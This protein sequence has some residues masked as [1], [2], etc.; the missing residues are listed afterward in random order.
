MQFLAIFLGRKVPTNHTSGK[1]SCE[2]LLDART[3][4]KTIAET[5]GITERTACNL[6]KAKNGGNDGARPHHAA[7]RVQRFLRENL[8]ALWPSDLWPPRSPDFN[9]LDQH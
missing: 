9:V 3:P 8:A 6:E 1:S 4:V 5:F 7:A 2:L